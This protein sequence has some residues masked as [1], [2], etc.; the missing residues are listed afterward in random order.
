MEKNLT[1]RPVARAAAAPAA[2]PAARPSAQVA[3]QAAR[4][5][6]AGNPAPDDEDLEEEER[7]GMA[8]WKHWLTAEASP[9]AISMLVHAGIFLIMAVV[10]GGSYIVKKV[11]EAAPTFKEVEIV[12]EEEKPEDE[13]KIEKF[14]L[15]TKAD[16][17]PSEIDLKE[18]QPVAIEAQEAV[19]F[20]DSDKFEE[21]GGGGFKNASDDGAQLGGGGV[22][23]EGIKAG[24]KSNG[25]GGVG[26]G[27]GF[28]DHAGLGGDGSGFGGR[29]KGSREALVGRYGGTRATER[30]VAAALNWL[31]RHQNRDGSWSI[32]TFNNN[33]KGGK[34]T[35]PGSKKSDSGATGLGLLPFLGAGQTHM[36]G[37]MYANSVRAGLDWLIT[38]QKKDGDLSAGAADQMYSHGLAAIALC[39]AYAMSGDSRIGFAAQAAIKF[40]ESA[41]NKQDGG[42]RYHPGEAGDTS[43]V[44]W[45]LMAL[46]SAQMAKLQI[47]PATFDG[48]NKWL[49]SVG[50]GDY[51][52]IFRYQPEREGNLPAMTAVGILCKE[53]LGAGRGDPALAEGIEF[54]MKNMPD[55][56]TSRNIYY[57]YYATQ[58]IHHM[59]GENWNKWNRKMRKVLV[60]TQVTGKGC[61][62]GSWD[63]KEPSPD[64]Y[65]GPGGRVMVTSLSCLTLEVYY[66]HLPLY[67]LNGEGAVKGKDIGGGKA[68]P[69]KP[70]AAKPAAPAKK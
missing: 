1:P 54:L 53:Y 15:E 17:D 3:N 29:G 63:P 24:P 36:N 11:T 18:T 16:E 41:Q 38:H 5:A 45:Q 40:I 34:C 20:D 57:W 66:R 55:E 59:L 14:D 68:A 47:N 26:A 39:E 9:Y 2:R 44:G 27:K 7:T 30:A 8:R 6:K 69:A 46:K 43:V 52:G 49:A 56:K 61:D 33:C 19:K 58:T 21:A 4:A 48:V 25:P 70:G 12:K 60:D 22:E 37:G 62:T 67:D 51:S 35:G 42:W 13:L 64:Q 28:G 32:D 23:F 10:L 50:K 65:G 31:Y